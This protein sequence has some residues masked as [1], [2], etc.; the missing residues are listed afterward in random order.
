MRPTIQ[1]REG[2]GNVLLKQP[3]VF[4][5]SRSAIKTRPRCL[6]VTFQDVVPIQAT[7]GSR[8]TAMSNE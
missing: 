2:L 3:R 8:S 1:G 4:N 5:F 7:D 6:T